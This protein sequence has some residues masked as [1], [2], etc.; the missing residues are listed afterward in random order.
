MVYERVERRQPKPVTPERRNQVFTLRDQGLSQGKIARQL[1]MSQTTVGRV[2][3]K[4]R[5]GEK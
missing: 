4:G 1:G 5:A 3:S 2:L